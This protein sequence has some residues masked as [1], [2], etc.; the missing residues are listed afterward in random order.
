MK[1]RKFDIQECCIICGNVRPDDGGYYCYDEED[2]IECIH[3]ETMTCRKF[4]INTKMSDKNEYMSDGN[5]K[6]ESTRSRLECLSEHEKFKRDTNKQQQRFNSLTKN[7]LVPATKKNYMEWL[8]GF[9][10]KDGDITNSYDYDMQLDNWVVATNDF[11]ISPLF[12]SMHYN[13][14]VPTGIVFRGG[15]EGHTNLYFMDKFSCIG[16]WVPIYNDTK[17]DE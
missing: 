11:K 16:G 1:M 3:P 5:K 8:A 6:I 14:I 10:D 4:E 13:I 2:L 7:K 15:A 12:G 9:L 17:L